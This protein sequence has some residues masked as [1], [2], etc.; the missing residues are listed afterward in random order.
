MI[1]HIVFFRWRHDL[2]E[3]QRRFAA[4]EVKSLQSITEIIQ[5]S[6]GENIARSNYHLVAVM[7]FRDRAGIDTFWRDTK[8]RKVMDSLK[9]L[10]ADVAMADFVPAGPH[11][12][13]V[14]DND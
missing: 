11:E 7:A 14:I 4:D 9:S 3:R 13:V 5:F 1:Q 6:C 12:A 8:H 2:S 10:I